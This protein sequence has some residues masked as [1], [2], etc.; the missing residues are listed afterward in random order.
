MNDVLIRLDKL[1]K[2]N[3]LLKRGGLSALVLLGAF[4]LMGQAP[5]KIIEAEKLILRS[6]SHTYAELGIDSSGTPA[7]TFFDDSGKTV[8]QYRRGEASIFGKDGSW[9]YLTEDRLM[10]TGPEGHI[11]LEPIRL[12]ITDT[13]SGL[14]KISLGMESSLKREG[15]VEPEMHFLGNNGRGFVQLSAIEGLHLEPGMF[16]GQV[17]PGG[18]VDI[19]AD[20]PSIEVQDQRGF[21]ST[22]GNVKLTIE[23]S[24]QERS[25]SASSIVLFAKDGK[26]IWSAP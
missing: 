3:R 26:V 24:G 2:E 10:L 12:S 23:R 21:K 20:G 19:S 9:S 22:I 7:L 13:K 8:S 16:H 15:V 4:V 14:G 5:S 6:G 25:T 11:D 18:F 1:E 17:L